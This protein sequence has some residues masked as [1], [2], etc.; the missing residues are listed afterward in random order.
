MKKLMLLL[1]LSCCTFF[2]Q[3]QDN[4][5]EALAYQYFQQG[6]FEKAASLFEKLFTKT[7]NDNYFDLYFTS[8]VKVKKYAEAEVMLKRL[9]KQFPQKTQYGVALGRVYQENGRTTEANKIYQEAINNTPKDETKFRDLANSFYRFEAY[10]MAIATFLQGRKLFGDE[11]LFI[12]EL[13][14]IYRFKKDKQMLIQ[15]Y[16]NALPGTPQIL[17]QAQ[18]VLAGVFEDNKDYLLLQAALLKKIQK[19]PQTEIYTDLLVWQYIQQQE[20]EMALRQLI[21]Q[22]K[23]TKGDGLNLYATANTF[24]ANRAYATAIKAYEYL[25]TKGPDSEYYLQAKVEL[26][27]AKY[28]LAISGKYDVL[29][30]QTLAQEYQD[31]LNQYGKNG[32]GFTALRKL[33]YLQAYYLKDLK[34]AEAT[35][36]DG[37]KVQG[38][39]ALDIGQL[40]MDLGD[41]YILTKQPWEAILVYE[42]VAKQF[43]NQAIGNEARY[44]SA[45][46]S[47]YQG[48]FDFAKSQADVLKVSTTNLIANDAIN[49]S[50]LISDNLQS[51]NDSLAL[52]MYADAEMLQFMNNPQQALAKLDSIG[53]AYPNNSL[54]D[55]ILM[56]KA[57]IYI[58]T[59]D[60]NNAVLLL[61][62]L[63]ATHHDSIWTDDAL[64]TLADLYEKKLNNIEEAKKLYQQ[65]MNDFP[66][67]MFNAEA[68]KRFRNIRGDNT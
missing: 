54:T 9:I 36:E 4:V 56:A 5:D 41:I 68:R 48:N 11:Q 57:K 51:K 8:L 26:V 58:K 15:E 42:Q 38:V 19:D 18:A 3:A 17:P 7:R 66:G 39:N 44:R 2:V 52:Q 31:I 53:I 35:L 64:F 37:L 50:L 67:S 46:L 16:I 61:K 45:R 28:E 14:S 1:W 24:L 32:Q 25:L 33:A 29:A 40:K 55:D 6:D 23:R 62:S 27:N 43:E 49:L 60:L 30:L 59:A 20:Y 47:F 34:K 13:L 65:L 63:I 10:D 22:D 12:Y 21:A